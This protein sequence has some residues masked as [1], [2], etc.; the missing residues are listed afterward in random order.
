MRDLEIRGAGSILGASQSGHMSAVGYDMYLKLL[1]EAV[2][3]QRGEEPKK[4][5]EC[6][7][8]V[9]VDAYIPE[10]YISNQAQRISCYK[11]IALI[12]TEDDAYD[13]TDELID[14]Y[15]EI[16]APVKGLIE[17]AQIRSTA[18]ELGISEIVQGKEGLAFYTDDLHMESIAKLNSKLGGRISLDLMGKT[19]FR[20]VP[21]KGEKTLAVIKMIVDGYGGKTA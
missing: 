1:D 14:R 8:D 20:I 4:E 3:E 9:K 16:P 6:L 17:V 18:Q 15:G 7:I 5:Q 10:D 19:C 21:E 11:R 2:K 12:R 13:V